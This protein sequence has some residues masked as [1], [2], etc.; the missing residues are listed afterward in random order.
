[1]IDGQ[2]PDTRCLLDPIVLLSSLCELAASVR[3]VYVG[4]GP[5]HISNACR[6]V[7]VNHGSGAFV[8]TSSCGK[9]VVGMLTVVCHHLGD[10]VANQLVWTPSLPTSSGSHIVGHSVSRET[11]ATS[12]RVRKSFSC[13][14]CHPRLPETAQSFRHLRA[15]NV[16]KPARTTRAPQ[17]DDHTPPPS[18]CKYKKVVLRGAVRH[19]ISAIHQHPETADT[20]ARHKLTGDGRHGATLSMCD[21]DDPFASATRRASSHCHD[22]VGAFK[23]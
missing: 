10:H 13:F 8:A 4:Y 11:A 1:M 14:R 16:S 9:G 19:P 22:G 15:A 21:L 17:R 5:S 2:M 12:P 20:A 3:G 6:R 23:D 7:D 18:T